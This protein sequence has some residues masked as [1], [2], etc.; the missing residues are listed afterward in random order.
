MNLNT[1]FQVA[2]DIQSKSI[3]IPEFRC[4]NHNVGVL[5]DFKSRSYVRCPIIKNMESEYELT[6]EDIL[7]LNEYNCSSNS[8]LT[9]DEFES[10]IQ[11][12]ELQRYYEKFVQFKC[13]RNF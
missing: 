8:G 1:P 2:L 4:N 5:R 13:G 11:F 7:F 10:I 9:E 6:S 12:K 3:Q